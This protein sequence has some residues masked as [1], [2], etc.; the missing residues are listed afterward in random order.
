MGFA[1]LGYAG[2]NLVE[3]FAPTPPARFM[4]PDLAAETHRRPGV[5][6]GSSPGPAADAGK[7]AKRTGQPL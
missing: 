1:L 2:A 6:L 7:P 3:A 4:D 5:S